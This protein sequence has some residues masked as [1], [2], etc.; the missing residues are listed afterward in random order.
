MNNIDPKI[1]GKHQ[2]PSLYY[3]CLAYPDKPTDTDKM[4]MRSYFTSLGYVLPCTTCIHNYKIHTQKHK[5]D[6][7]A[8]S[9]RKNLIK[10]LISINNSVNDTLNK[11]HVTYEEIMKKYTTK[12]LSDTFIFDKQ[13]IQMIVITIMIIVLVYYAKN[14]N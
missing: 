9:S 5:L 3:I 11:P 6:N 12:P 4:N 13:I 10:W 7:D 8:L 14:R 1:W 2:W